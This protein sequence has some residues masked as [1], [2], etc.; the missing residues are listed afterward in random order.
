MSRENP[1]SMRSFDLVENTHYIIRYAGLRDKYSGSTHYDS[2]KD[3]V[4]LPADRVKSEGFYESRTVSAYLNAHI[5]E[6][7]K[8]SNV[9][10]RHKVVMVY[11]P[12]WALK[13]AVALRGVIDNDR[14]IL[15]RLIL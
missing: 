15:L 11:S 14:A 10:L 9:V 6:I 3:M 5:W 12:V 7:V 4:E 1:Y 8:D 13:N 2:F